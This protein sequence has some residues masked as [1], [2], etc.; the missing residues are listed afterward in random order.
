MVKDEEELLDRIKQDPDV[1]TGKPVIKGTRLTV[2][3][4]IRLLAE[5]AS[6]EDIIDEYDDLSEKDLRACLL[7]AAKLLDDTHVKPLKAEKKKSFD[8]IVK[9]LRE[10]AEELD[11][12]KEEVEGIVHESKEEA[13]EI[14]EEKFPELS[15]IKSAEKI[16]KVAEKDHGEEDL[17]EALLEQRK[18]ED[19]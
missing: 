19:V 10:K 12:K 13:G 17:T 6:I 3:F 5:G 11:L 16:D 4:V 7:F 2:Q 15:S 1:M 18:E 8:E 14:L 9:P